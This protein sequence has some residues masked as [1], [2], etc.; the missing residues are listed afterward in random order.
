MIPDSAWFPLRVTYSREMKVKEYLD[1]LEVA[2][3]IP[4]H[5][6]ERE[7]NGVKER[8]SV[9]VIHNLI[10]VH[11]DRETIDRIKT[12]SPYASSIRYIMDAVTKKPLTIPN[13]QMQD[14]IAVSGKEEEAILYLTPAEVSLKRGDKVRIKSGIWQG[15]EGKFVRIQR[16]LRVVVTIEGIMAVA[17][18]SLHPS[19]VEVII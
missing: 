8:K 9:P 11:T 3:F 1:S 12:H 18:A 4:M 2:S 5:C 14:F 17:T 7:R 13:K 10:F 16:G 15:I 19:Q 6:V